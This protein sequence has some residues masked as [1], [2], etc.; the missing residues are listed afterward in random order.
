M[1]ALLISGTGAL[2]GILVGI[3]IPSLVNFALGFFP[4]VGNVSLPL[5]WLSVVAALVV[6]CSTG[7]IFG[8]LPANRAAKL[9]PNESLRY[10]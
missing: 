3:S 5:S 6:A 10:E 2:A 4:E 7:L 9:H 1:E 8:F